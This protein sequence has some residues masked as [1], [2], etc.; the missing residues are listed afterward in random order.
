MLVGLR[1]PGRYAGSYWRARA[2]PRSSSSVGRSRCLVCLAGPVTA[3]ASRSDARM[4]RPSPACPLSPHLMT[5][6]VL[7]TCADDIRPANRVIHNSRRP[8]TCG[9]TATRSCRRGTRTR[10]TRNPWRHGWR[11][12]E[13]SFRV[14]SSAHSTASVTVQ[15]RHSIGSTVLCAARR[16]RKA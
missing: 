11:L 8:L 9:N 7:M 13:G 15:T 6:G 10:S 5:R 3:S 2:C 1:S 16:Q 14:S 12:R 4:N